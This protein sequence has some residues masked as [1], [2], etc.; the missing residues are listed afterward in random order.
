MR[1]GDGIGVA[2]LCLSVIPWVIMLI[3]EWLQPG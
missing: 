1:R 2:G 3:M